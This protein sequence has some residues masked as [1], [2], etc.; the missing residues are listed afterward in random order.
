MN[1]PIGPG[2]AE[3]YPFD[4][5]ARVENLFGLEKLRAIA[6]RSTAAYLFEMYWVCERNERDPKFKA[7]RAREEQ[8]K[9]ELDLEHLN[10]MADKAAAGVYGKPAQKVADEVLRGGQGRTNLEALRKALRKV[11]GRISG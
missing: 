11:P 10:S 7:Q 8:E 3:D 9:A 4:P 1:A 6:D 5:E 2:S